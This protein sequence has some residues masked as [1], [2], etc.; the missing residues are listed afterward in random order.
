MIEW[1]HPVRS[2]VSGALSCSK[3]RSWHQS[4][5]NVP[6]PRVPTSPS[7]VSAAAACSTLMRNMMPKSRE[8]RGRS[9]LH[10]RREICFIRFSLATENSQGGRGEE[11][12]ACPGLRE[13]QS[14]IADIISTYVGKEEMHWLTG[15]GGLRCSHLQL[16]KAHCLYGKLY[17]CSS[18]HRGERQRRDRNTRRRKRKSEGWG[19]TG[20]KWETITPNCCLSVKPGMWYDGYNQWIGSS[21]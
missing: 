12:S 2:K 3:A 17:P 15:R 5:Q 11:G 9:R 7:P 21:P 1:N 13:T 6:C 18:L 10:N 20:R 16:G 14:V 8:R 4:G 19:E